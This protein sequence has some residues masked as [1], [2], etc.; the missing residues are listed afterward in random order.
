MP[1]V[2]QNYNRIVNERK[3]L[4]NPDYLGN[5]RAW[6]NQIP[7]SGWEV[8]ERPDVII[9]SHYYPHRKGGVI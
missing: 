9:Q 1:V 2:K 3:E 4:Q 7:R 6:R 8:G 5:T